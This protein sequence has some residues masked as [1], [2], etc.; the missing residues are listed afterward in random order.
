M[1]LLRGPTW[2]KVEDHTKNL[3]SDFVENAKS[4]THCSNDSS[5]AVI[6][7]WN[8]GIALLTTRRHRETDWTSAVGVHVG[9]AR[10]GSTAP[11]RERRR[12]P[13]G[14]HRPRV[15]LQFLLVYPGLPDLRCVWPPYQV[16]NL[17]SFPQGTRFSPTTGQQ[18]EVQHTLERNCCHRD[19]DAV[20]DAVEEDTHQ[21]HLA[22]HNMGRRGGRGEAPNWRA[23]TSRTMR[24]QKHIR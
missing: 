10:P 19:R 20:G 3:S 1:C 4:S 6:P 8:K 11:T 17:P 12:F 18:E 21:A 5:V 16:S 9:V 24:C 7:T 22:S 2:R 14:K 13:A 15:Q 23:F